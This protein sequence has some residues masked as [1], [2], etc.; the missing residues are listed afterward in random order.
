MYIPKHF[1]APSQE[2]ILT[3]ISTAGASD[4]ITHD[5]GEFQVTSLPFLFET[6]GSDHGSLLGHVARANPHWQSVDGSQGLVIMRGPSA[7]VSPSV[8]PS[9]KEHQKVVPTWNYVAVHLV[10]KIFVHE[11]TPWLRDVVTRLTDH[12][13]AVSTQ[14]WSVSDAPEEFIESQLRAIVGIEFVITRI[15]AKYKLSQ[16]RVKADAEAVR[17]DMYRRSEVAMYKAMDW[18]EG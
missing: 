1:S 9:K 10:G 8:Y 4:L 7:Y 13:E 3:T 11:E 2:D 14:P 5:G 12:F 15:E 16:N 17:C 18:V 6:D